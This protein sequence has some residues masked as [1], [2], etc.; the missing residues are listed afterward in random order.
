MVLPYF[1][2][3]VDFIEQ[4]MSHDL[5][6]SD[7]K[8]RQMTKGQNFWLNSCFICIE[9][10]KLYLWSESHENIVLFHPHPEIKF[11]KQFILRK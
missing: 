10:R 1:C 3:S 4:I 2:I 11:Q 5:V 6:V 7:L 8:W 9:T